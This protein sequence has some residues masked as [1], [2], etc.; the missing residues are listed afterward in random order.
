LNTGPSHDPAH[1]PHSDT[2]PVGGDVPMLWRFAQVEFDEHRLELRLRGEAVR[3]ERAPLR[4]LLML[5]RNA[6]EI[7]GYDTLLNGVWKRS[8]DTISRNAVSNAIAKLRRAIGDDQQTIIVAAPQSGYRIAVPV[9]A[10]EAPLQGRF[11]ELMRPGE[12]VPGAPH[13]MLDRE[14]QSSQHAAVWVAIERGSGQRSVFKFAS[15]SHQLAA[16][17]REAKIARMLRE[18]LGDRPEFV[19]QLE[20]QFEHAP[21]FIRSEFGGEDLRAWVDARGGWARIAL[22]Q[23]LDL[24]ARFADAVAL[25]HGIGLLHKDLKPGNLLVATD[26]DGGEQV[27]VIDFGSGQLINSEILRRYDISALVGA[28]A[29]SDRNALMYLAPELLVGNPPTLASDVY[30]FGVL[31]YQFVIGDLRRPI[32]PSWEADIEDP[33]LR[34]DIVRATHGNPALRSHSLQEFATRLR[35]LPRRHETQRIEL[36]R[37][38]RMRSAEQALRLSRARRPWI[39]AAIGLFATGFTASAY[40]GWVASRERDHAEAQFRLARSINDFLTQGFLL[41]AN[42]ARGGDPRI[43]VVDAMRRAANHLDRDLGDAPEALAALH[44]VLG[45]NFLALQENHEAVEH[46]RRASALFASL[47]DAHGDKRLNADCDLAGAQ[48]MSGDAPGAQQHGQQIRQKLEGE[49]EGDLSFATRSKCH[50]LLSMLASESGDKQTAIREMKAVAELVAANDTATPQQRGLVRVKYGM[51]LVN[52]GQQ[53]EGLSLIRSVVDDFSQRFG[54]DQF[55]TLSAL[56]VLSGALV[57]SGSQAEAIQVLQRVLAGYTK[58][59]GQN[60]V[61]AQQVRQRLEQLQTTA[62]PAEESPTGPP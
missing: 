3:I 52:N 6:G 23:R 9:S 22:P 60:S 19:T 51:A 17:R 61:P 50:Q 35:E 24:L 49:A 4:V 34:E 62:A 31:L 26:A 20:T 41:A 2:A 7:V 15:Q 12:P 40:L 44:Q 58:R 37:E 10:T 30:A 56:S 32:T 29:E 1:D 11:G 48:L 18:A 39:Y 54:E 59:M 14:L 13:W 45:N 57:A 5:L 21:Y 42:P 25:A 55:E 38:Q 8:R 43:S 27:R 47:P 53:A 28:A 33:L 46:F 36:E 16:L